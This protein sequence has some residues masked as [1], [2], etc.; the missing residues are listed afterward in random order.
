VLLV[1]GDGSEMARSA[2]ILAQYE[3]NASRHLRKKKRQ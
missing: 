2:L 3:K 1:P